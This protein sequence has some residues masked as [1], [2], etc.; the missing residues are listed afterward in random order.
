MIVFLCNCKETLKYIT[1]VKELPSSILEILFNLK[2]FVVV[3]EAV[4]RGQRCSAKKVLL[5]FPK[6][7]GKY[8]CLSILFNKVADLRRQNLAETD[9]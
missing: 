5:N 1:K 8:L 6:F 2:N 3:S 9:K 7:T 4:V